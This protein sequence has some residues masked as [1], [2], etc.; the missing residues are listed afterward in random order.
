MGFAS[1]CGELQYL[2]YNRKFYLYIILNMFL[3]TYFDASL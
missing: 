1:F 3:V 2:K